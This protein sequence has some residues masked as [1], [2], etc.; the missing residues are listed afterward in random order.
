MSAKGAAPD[1]LALR[2]AVLTFRRPADIQ[3]A[4]P[5]LV[6]QAISVMDDRVTADIVVVDNDP[7]GSAE[8]F[9]TSFAQAHPEVSVHYENETTPGISAAR[10][11]ALESAA[12]R[13]LLV[14][15]DDDERP[16]PRWLATLLATYEH[17][18]SAAVVGPVIS[19]YE[20]PP[21]AWVEDGRFFTRRRLPTGTQV[22]VAA[23]NNLLLDL[24][25]VRRLGLTFD[26]R[27]GISGGGDTMFTRR[28]HRRG[29]QL[30][31]CDEAP[32]TDV[33]PAARVTRDWVVRRALRMGNSWSATSLALAATPAERLL[34]RGQA[35]ARGLLRLG[36]GGARF[37]VGV[38]RRSQRHRAQGTR[39]LVR[40]AGMLLGAWG[41][42]YQEYRRSANHSE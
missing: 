18:R 41:Y 27:F 33:V 22:D 13:D 19:E 30:V 42:S 39:T 32:V 35:S 38:A 15:I 10:N 31:W 16:S 24:H 23:T 1:S 6:E 5:R 12:D 14:F 40:G 20:V 34:V 29:G 21:E 4:L 26:P 7:S 25:Q 37:L 36:G 9:V 28:L 2:I 8:S 17:Y 3:A 11:R